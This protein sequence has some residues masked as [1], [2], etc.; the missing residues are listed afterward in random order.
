[1]IYKKLHIKDLEVN[2]SNDR[3]GELPS[4]NDAIKWLLYNKTQKMKELLKD[5][6]LEIKS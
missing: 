1:M 6:V 5:I 3:H 2:P 4:E